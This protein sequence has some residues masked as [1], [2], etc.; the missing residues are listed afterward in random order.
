MKILI[1][2]SGIAG[3]GLANKLHYTKNVQ[4]Q[5][6]KKEPELLIQ[7]HYIFHRMV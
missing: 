2:G 7:V 4:V 3:L 1:I 6:I 5:L